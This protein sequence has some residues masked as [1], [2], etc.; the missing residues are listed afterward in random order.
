M[1]CQCGP[2][3]QGFE[4]ELDMDAELAQMDSRGKAKAKPGERFSAEG[5]RFKNK[6]REKRDEK[7]GAQQRMPSRLVCMVLERPLQAA[8]L[9]VE[10]N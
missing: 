8:L 1:T 7:F 2:C 3:L 4:G 9:F 10:L 5:S 6:K